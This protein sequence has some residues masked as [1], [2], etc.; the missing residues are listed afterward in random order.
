MES[1]D[2]QGPCT[3]LKVSLNPCLPSSPPPPA[4][5]VVTSPCAW[6]NSLHV[7]SRMPQ[8]ALLPV[9]M[10]QKLSIANVARWLC[11]IYP[12]GDPTAL[13]TDPVLQCLVSSILC[14]LVPASCTDF[15]ILPLHRCIPYRHAQL[16]TSTWMHAHAYMQTHSSH[17]C[18]TSTHCHSAHS[19]THTLQ[20]HECFAVPFLPLPRLQS[21]HRPS[22]SE[23][24][25]TP[26]DS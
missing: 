26:E 4:L 10:A 13:R 16:H 8:S 11:S 18:Y 5:T 25:S 24:T 20:P 6:H 1:A 9:T 19:W 7:Q 14:R 15:I 17:S 21:C 3:I 12:S 23:K 22:H 2:R